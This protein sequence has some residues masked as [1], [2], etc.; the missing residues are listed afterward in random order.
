[1]QCHGNTIGTFPDLRTSGALH[2]AEAFDAIVRGGV[3]AANGMVSF[4]PVLSA[5]DAEAIRAY[6]ITLAVE[7]KA[8]ED[9][10]SAAATARGEPH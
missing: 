2:S 1:M 7:A 3:L 10:A 4:A 5:A 8:A 9:A 6:V